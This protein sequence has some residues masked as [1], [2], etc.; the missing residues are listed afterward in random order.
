MRKEKGNE[1][2]KEWNEWDKIGNSGEYDISGIQDS[3]QW[4]NDART[5]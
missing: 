5:I 2:T 3:H 4:R 1:M